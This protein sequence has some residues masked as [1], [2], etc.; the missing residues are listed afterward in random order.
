MARTAKASGR[1]H[2]PLAKRLQPV[3]GP[4]AWLER[5]PA[6]CSVALRFALARAR[7]VWEGP[8]GTEAAALRAGLIKGLPLCGKWK[9]ARLLEEAYNLPII[10]RGTSVCYLLPVLKS[11]RS[12]V[13]S[14]NF[15]SSFFSPFPFPSCFY[16]T[17]LSPN[18]VWPDCVPFVKFAI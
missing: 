15:S 5:V 6:L 13:L 1:F 17:Q 16:A 10:F 11:A 7:R 3:C 8:L 4:S 2:L 12:K 18:F 9:A 14:F